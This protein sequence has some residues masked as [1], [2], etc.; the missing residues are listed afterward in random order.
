MGDEKEQ[1]LRNWWEK[2][3]RKIEDAMGGLRYERSRD[4]GRR[5]DNNNKT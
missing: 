5:M 2:E 4:S 3:A 1:M